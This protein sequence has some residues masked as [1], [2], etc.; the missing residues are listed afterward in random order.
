MRISLF[1]I[2]AFVILTIGFSFLF[3]GTLFRKKGN[4]AGEEDKKKKGPKRDPLDDL[5]FEGLVDML[6]LCLIDPTDTNPSTS[7]C[8]VLKALHRR[9]DKKKELLADVPTDLKQKVVTMLVSFLEAANVQP[10]VLTDTIVAVG[11]YVIDDPAL[12]TFFSDAGGIK[13]L[14]ACMRD[15]STARYR[16][17]AKWYFWAF[18][19]RVAATPCRCLPMRA[20]SH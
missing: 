6:S 11:L 15:K 17:V 14:H 10:D 1:E 16:D 12:Q 5:S 13:A 7:A 8:N 4:N 9:L 20:L 19:V 18:S 2:V 3:S